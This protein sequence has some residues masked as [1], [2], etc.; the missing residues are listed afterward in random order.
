MHIKHTIYI[1]I[2]FS[3]IINIVKTASEYEWTDPS[4]KT[5][6]DISGL[7]RSEE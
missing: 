7:V 5:K 4:T 1:L 2:I 6:Y 3:N